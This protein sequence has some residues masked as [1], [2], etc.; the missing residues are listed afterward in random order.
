MLSASSGDAPAVVAFVHRDVVDG[1]EL[2]EP[3]RKHLR[4]TIDPN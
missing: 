4:K 2:G 1:V 3:L